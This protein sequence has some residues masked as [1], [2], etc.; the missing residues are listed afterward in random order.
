MQAEMHWQES[1]PRTDAD[2]HTQKGGGGTH[3]LLSA[4]F[5]HP[6]AELS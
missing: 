4:V 6:S 5:L 1:D 2:M 3:H